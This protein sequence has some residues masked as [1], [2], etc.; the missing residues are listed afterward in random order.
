MAGLFDV[1]PAT[2]FNPLA[3]QGA[4]VYVDALLRLFAETQRHQQP[5]LRS[6]ALSIVSDAISA[7]EALALTAE[8]AAEGEGGDEQ[9]SPVEARAAAI[10]RYL[11]RSGWLRPETQS[12]F[13][14]TYILPAYAFR[15]LDTL[16]NLAANERPR[17]Q[18][19]ICAIHDLL[20]AAVKDGNAHIRLPEAHHQTRYLLTSLKELQ[21]NI[22]AHIE[23]VL[24]QLSAR[25]VLA[26]VFT[27]YRSEIV[28]RAYHQLRTT[29]HVSRFRPG[30]VQALAEL[31]ND[32]QI[33]AMA[34]RLRASGEATSVELAVT[35]LL[36]QTQEIREQFEL[37]DRLLQAIDV[38]HS[39]FIEL[40]GAGGRAT[41]DR[42]RHDQ[43]PA[44]RA[45]VAPAD[46][47]DRPQ[48]RAAARCL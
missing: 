7:P 35:Q 6:L 27:T 39:Q 2:L 12:D 10:L 28:D 25:D 26:Q 13:T 23:A 47:G 8:A 41:A 18:G 5:L 30:V 29:D 19:L 37:L 31:R 33:A 32:T 44:A 34:Q 17:L 40:G 1:V 9:A 20:Q 21:H 38:R 24:Q 48:R 16:T 22:G 15:L 46:R 11:T 4:P 3:A 36:D 45:A 14:V 42:Q 43:R